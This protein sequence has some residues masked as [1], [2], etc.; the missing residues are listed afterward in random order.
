M[1]TE[2]DI[3]PVPIH[4]KQGERAWIDWF[5]AVRE[6]LNEGLQAGELTRI[7]DVFKS[8]S[9]TQYI[10]EKTDD[11]RKRIAENEFLNYL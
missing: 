9:Q 6:K 4:V 2:N 5:R 3:P 7:L 8:G 10:Q 1:A 11:N